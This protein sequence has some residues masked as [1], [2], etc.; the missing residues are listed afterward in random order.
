MVPIEFHRS[1][2]VLRGLEGISKVGFCGLLYGLM[3]LL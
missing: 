1:L 2:I 3:R